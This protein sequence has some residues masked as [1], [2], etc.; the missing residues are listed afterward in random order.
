[1]RRRGEND[2]IALLEDDPHV[3]DIIN[4]TLGDFGFRTVTFFNAT[5]FWRDVGQHAPV[6]CII[7]LNLP[8][9][10]G[11]D[12]VDGIRGQMS[13][14]ILILTGRDSL[15]ERVRGLECGADDYIVKPFEPRELVALC[16]QHTQALPAGYC[17]TNP[18]NGTLP[19]VGF[20]C[21]DQ[22]P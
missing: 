5:D 22:Y 18:A 4:R 19:G 8:D 13:C 14:G 7:D 9:A 21:V 11:I 2:L 12:V 10:D 17:E 15:S 1:M 6:L 16:T 3:T 20:R